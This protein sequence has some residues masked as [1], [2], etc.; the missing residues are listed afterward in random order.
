MP[1]LVTRATVAAPAKVNLILRV[2]GRRDD[3][4]HLLESLM[5]P[6]SLC[7][8]VA[9]SARPLR[10]GPARVTCRVTG[11][12]RVPGG[13]TNLAA[14]AAERVLVELDAVAEVAIR[15][16]KI[17]PHGAGLGGGA[18]TPPPCSSRS[19]GCCAAESRR[20]A[21]P[22]WRR[23][24]VRTFR[25]FWRAVP[26]GRR[27]SANASPRSASRR[28]RCTWW[29]SSRVGGSRPLGPT[30]TRCRRSRG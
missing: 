11:A 28:S 10:A 24:S 23:I 15:L 16:R 12:A 3:G 29:L 1:G 22:S 13:S 19:R 21:W 7:D 18:A 9:I 25:S 14:R 4:Y 2:V 17:I 27:V 6:V 26:L 30:P 8:A 20:L 5:V